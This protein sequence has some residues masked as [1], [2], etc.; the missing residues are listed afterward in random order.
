M[1]CPEFKSKRAYIEV[2]VGTPVI[3]CFSI[4]RDLRGTAYFSI[5]TKN[6]KLT[7][8]AEGTVFNA[9]NHTDEEVMMYVVFNNK[10]YSSPECT[11]QLGDPYI[12][13]SVIVA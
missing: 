12:K 6:G 8:V 13:E 7:Q 11:I 4:Y 10:F 9:E 3:Y 2:S 1:F 5:K